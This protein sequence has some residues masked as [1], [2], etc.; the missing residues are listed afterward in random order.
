MISPMLAT[1]GSTR[2]EDYKDYLF[3]LKIDG[4]RAIVE[5]TGSD[6]KIYSRNKT[7]MTRNFPEIREEFLK[8]KGDFIIDGELVVVTENSPNRAATISRGGKTKPME[9]SYFS[10]KLPATYFAFDIVQSRE[11]GD[12]KNTELTARVKV[13][14]DEI[15]QGERI[16]VLE[17][18]EYTGAQKLMDLCYKNN[19]E[20]LIA[21]NPISKYQEDKRSKDWIKMKLTKED[22]LEVLGFS[23]ETREIS[24]LFTSKGKVNFGVKRETYDKWLPVLKEMSSGQERIGYG[25]KSEVGYPIKRGIFITARHYGETEGGIMISPQLQKIWREG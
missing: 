7:L 2:V 11:H 20:G 4:Y 23:S 13:L 16:K 5:K 9:I 8:L 17:Y 14:K 3:N 18:V 15:P 22:D 24:A 19:W 21:K 1:K 25:N 12:M 10:K 6:V